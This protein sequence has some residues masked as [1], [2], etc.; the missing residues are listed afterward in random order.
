VIVLDS[1]A[2]VHLFAG[3]DR[4]DWVGEQ[5]RG[6]SV[7]APYLAEVEVANALRGLVARGELSQPDAR[8]ALDDYADLALRRYAHVLF[9]D[10]IWQLRTHV[11]AYDA[12]YI[13]LSEALDAPLVTTDVRLARTR[14]HCARIVAPA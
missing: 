6:E 11:T 10:R 3:L 8:R 7:H 14:G 12:V 13:A 9:L 1:S 4:A 5:I 2:T